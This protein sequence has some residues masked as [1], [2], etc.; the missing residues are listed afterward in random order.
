MGVA[1]NSTNRY[2]P[3]TTEEPSAVVLTNVHPVGSVSV[4]P[5]PGD[6]VKSELGVR[7]I[8]TVAPGAAVVGMDLVTVPAASAG[9]AIIASTTISSRETGKMLYVVLL[10]FFHPENFLFFQLVTA[11]TFNAVAEQAVDIIIRR[12]GTFRFR[13]NY[14]ITP[15]SSSVY[16]TLIYAGIRTL[17]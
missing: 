13:F 17:L 6:V 7:V 4:A 10:I 11:S 14:R 16:I 12:E 3:A 15:F 1:L 8:V 2:A 9:A 5:Q